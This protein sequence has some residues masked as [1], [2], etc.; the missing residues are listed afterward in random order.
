MGVSLKKPPAGVLR[1]R[2][3]DV[4][5]CVAVQ[6]RIRRV[7]RAKTLIHPNGPSV[8]TISDWAL[9]NDKTMA[10]YLL[11]HREQGH[12][13]PPPIVARVI[14]LEHERLLLE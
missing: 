2:A 3:R 5:R 1:Y 8:S 12:R 11:D 7:L 10:R 6:E 9:V 13:C 14:E 4:V